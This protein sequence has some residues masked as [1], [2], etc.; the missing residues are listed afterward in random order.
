MGEG[1]WDDTLQEWLMYADETSGKANCC[2]GGMAGSDGSGFYAACP[3]EGEAGWA[4]IYKD[5]HE[6]PIT[7]E[8]GETK[9]PTL[10][11]EATN[12]LETVNNLKAP[13][14]GLWLGGQKY[15]VTQTDPALESGDGTFKYLFANRP[16]QGVHILVTPVS[17]QIVCA[18]YDEEKGNTSGNCKKT[19]LAFGEYLVAQG[20]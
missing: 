5:D 14:T 1:S 20:Y 16:K 8:D 3:K 13:K 9:V 19:L 6:E 10:I 15:T 7:Q 18:F 11:N 2:A 12:L 17:S 4:H